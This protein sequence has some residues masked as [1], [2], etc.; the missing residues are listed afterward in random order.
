MIGKLPTRPVLAAAD[1]DA[2]ADASAGPS[3]LVPVDLAAAS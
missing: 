1:L 3:R 2:S